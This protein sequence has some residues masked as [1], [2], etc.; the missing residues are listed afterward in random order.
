MGWANKPSVNS[1]GGARSS[2]PVYRSRTST[3]DR[4][5]P[6]S[7]GVDTVERKRSSSVSVSVPPTRHDGTPHLAA[8]PLTPQV[9]TD[10]LNTKLDLERLFGLTSRA[11]TPEAARKDMERDWH[12][13]SNDAIEGANRS[14]AKKVR[15]AR[16]LRSIG[17]PVVARQ[18]NTVLAVAE[19]FL[20]R[21]EHEVGDAAGRYAPEPERTKAKLLFTIAR[22]S[23]SLPV[24]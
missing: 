21:L 10:V 14:T 6:I 16:G 15:R 2:R 12:E 19:Q 22:S 1:T 13:R 20:Q 4:C 3:G 17:Q 18:R 5:R 24:L 9:N 7:R 11:S 23:A 8:D